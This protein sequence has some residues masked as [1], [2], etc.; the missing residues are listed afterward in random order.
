MAELTLEPRL[1]NSSE[2]MGKQPGGGDWEWCP[3]NGCFGYNLGRGGRKRRKNYFKKVHNIL[4][5]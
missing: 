1:C 3:G 2:V 5:I 4:F